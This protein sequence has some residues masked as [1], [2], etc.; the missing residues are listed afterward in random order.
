MPPR[1]TIDDLPEQATPEQTNYLII[2][3]D[4]VTKKMSIDSLMQIASDPLA[5]HLTDSVDAHDATAI[6]TTTAGP[7]V[8]GITVQAQLG[9]LATLIDAVNTQIASI[10]SSIAANPATYVN[11][12]GDTMSGPLTLPASD[13]VGANDATRKAYVDA[14]TTNKVTKTGDAMTGDLTMTDGSIILPAG[15]SGNLRVLRDGVYIENN[16]VLEVGRNAV[17]GG[18]AR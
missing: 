15:G 4:G 5:A 12:T 3:D 14:N 13:P 17:S 18:G 16:S 6:S 2:Q 10:N 9:Q 8:D 1:V 7:S 11:A